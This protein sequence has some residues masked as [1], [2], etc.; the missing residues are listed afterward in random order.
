MCVFLD[1]D[2]AAQPVA[3]ARIGVDDSIG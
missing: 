2:R 1:L 3:H